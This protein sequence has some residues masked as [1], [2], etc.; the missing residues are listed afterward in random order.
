MCSQDTFWSPVEQSLL[1][2]R[3]HSEDPIL[4]RISTGD[5]TK[6]KILYRKSLPGRLSK[7]FGSEAIE[8]DADHVFCVSN[9]LHLLAKDFADILSMTTWPRYIA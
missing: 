4:W 3:P 2:G 8:N 9:T 6:V 7:K 5:L 1:K